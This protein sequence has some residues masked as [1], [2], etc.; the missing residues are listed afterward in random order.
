MRIL[1]LRAPIQDFY[2]TQSRRMPLGLLY[3]SSY[4]KA[5]G[6]SVDFFDPLE[7]AKSRTIQIPKKLQYLKKYYLQDDISPYN[8]YRNYCHYGKSFDEIEDYIRLHKYDLYIISSLFTPYHH[9]SIKLFEIIKKYNQHSIIVTGGNHVS[10]CLEQ[11]I[12]HSLVDYAITGEG[13]RPLLQLIQSLEGKST[14]D[15]INGLSFKLNNKIYTNR[16]LNLINDLDDIPFPDRSVINFDDYIIN[17]KKSTMIIS[18]RG[19]NH[20]CSFCSTNKVFG[21]K[22]R[23]RSVDNVLDEM[24]TCY[25]QFGIRSFDFEDDSLT[26][27]NNFSYS[28]FNA[29]IDEFGNSINL[30]AMNGLNYYSLNETLI[31]KMKL[32][33]FYYFNISLVTH[34]HQHQTALNRP[35]NSNS[36]FENVI[37]Q[38]FNL[39]MWSVGYFILGLPEQTLLDVIDTVMYLMEKPVLIGP[40]VYYPTPGTK[41][42]NDCIKQGLI[43]IEDFDLYCST[44][45][46][47]ETKHLNR[48]SIVTI[49]RLCRLINS[50]KKLLDD[51]V[52]T[53]FCLT[54]LLKNQMPFEELLNN[55][56]DNSYSI[57]SRTK[58]KP[59][60]FNL[61][62][63]KLFFLTK[64]VYKL[65]KT[66]VVRPEKHYK[67]ILQP[68]DVSTDVLN[69]FLCKLTGKTI[70]GSKSKNYFHI[71]IEF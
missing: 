61:L 16:K 62:L 22:Q 42:Y 63:I 32:A 36:S 5:N 1:L 68:C 49:F 12:E 48:L 2:F 46:S 57:K 52:L 69:S 53:Y 56:N 51:D 39:K 43:E 45:I 8:L 14:L 3:L 6:Y 41:K 67:Y 64:A 40:S 23:I 59:I 21:N 31:K 38:V 71:D 33:G 9:L 7:K 11:V 19:C 60:E 44:A 15:N 70:Y 26:C 58:V 28:L 37:Q 24:Q 66:S 47:V 17:S 4:L 27:D 50:I 18:T 30:F 55:N 34:K 13:E 10:C 20:N 65:I 35:G 29:I 25:N 54:N